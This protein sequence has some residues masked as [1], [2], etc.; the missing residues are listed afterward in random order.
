MHPKEEIKRQNLYIRDVKLRGEKGGKMK[1]NYF[2]ILFLIMFFGT[3]SYGAE[4]IEY[5]NQNYG[6]VSVFY[7]CPDNDD[8]NFSDVF[9]RFG[10]NDKK[11]STIAI[12]FVNRAYADRKV[13][14]A[15]KDVTSKKMVILDPVHKSRFGTEMLKSNSTGKIWSGP[16][17][18][19]NDSFTLR[20]WDSAGDQFDKVPI[21][22]KDQ[23]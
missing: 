22:I 9:F 10:W 18:N 17:D 20:V 19:I 15:I 5:I 23:Q 13:K 7:S 8:R 14:F 16:V 2:P 3:Q 21:S 4:Q 11:P 12:Q 1:K 6:I